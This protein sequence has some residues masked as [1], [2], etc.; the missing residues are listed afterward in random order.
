MIIRHLWLIHLTV[1][2]SV[3]YSFTQLSISLIA[4]FVVFGLIL[5]PI[6]VE[7]GFHR[8]FTHRSFRVPW[9][10]HWILLLCCTF[11]S[12]G[13]VGFWVSS[14]KLHHRYSDT[15]RDWHSPKQSGF[16]GS[17]FAHWGIAQYQHGDRI[18][19]YRGIE[20]MKSRFV[21]HTTDYYLPTIIVFMIT[22]YAISPVLYFAYTWLVL[23]IL[24]GEGITN[25]VGH[26]SGTSDNHPRLQ[27]VLC[28]TGVPYHH[29]HH[30]KPY[31]YRME[32][33][34]DPLGWFIDRI[35]IR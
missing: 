33:Y 9:L 2:L 22:L 34:F 20:Y 4:L 8:Y 26:I 28:W 21:R 6:I 25:S 27:Y 13:P 19:Q 35:R 7:V 18:I 32:G 1:V 30:L 14:H 17:F 29:Y 10:T 16:W 31:A 23:I 15:E 11:A 5:G 24:I 12:M 3:L